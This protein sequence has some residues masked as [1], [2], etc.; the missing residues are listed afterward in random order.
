MDVAARLFATREAG[1]QLRI[2][3]GQRVKAASQC[4]R[5]YACNVF[6]QMGE[7]G[8][9]SEIFE[10]IG[11]RNYWCCEIG[12][13]DGVTHSNTR[14]LVRWQT[15]HGVLI[16]ADCE[17]YRRLEQA[18]DHNSRV[19]TSRRFADLNGGGLDAILADTPIPMDFDFLSIDID[20]CDWYLWQQMQRY[21]PRV[22]LIEFNASIANHVYFVQP[23]D[24]SVMW[25]SS[26]RALME[27]GRE[28]G[29][30]LAATTPINAFFVLAE[31]FPRLGIE[32]N[33]LDAMHDGDEH[34]PV[35]FQNYCGEWVF[36]KAPQL[37]AKPSN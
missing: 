19:F 8:I 31:D 12:A 25:G 32:D 11:I 20:G 9:R 2:D 1:M 27:L 22:V 14:S 7:D 23:H 6:S 30:E 26:L 21:R 16:E 28:K 15:W 35:I 17:K 3:S 36:A 29:Y 37:W 33:S 24:Q 13:G 10:R 18:Y 4:L 5:Q 34:A